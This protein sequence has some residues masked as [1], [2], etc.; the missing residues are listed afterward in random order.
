MITLTVISETCA[1]LEE[2]LSIHIYSLEPGPIEVRGF[3][4]L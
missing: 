3:K 4:M 1:E 2:G